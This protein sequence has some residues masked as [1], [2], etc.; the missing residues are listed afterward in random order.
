M[1]ERS[2]LICMALALNGCTTLLNT[3]AELVASKCRLGVPIQKAQCVAVGIHPS[4]VKGGQLEGLPVSALK[5]GD[6]VVALENLPEE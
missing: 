1:Y 6:T 3:P 2:F 4:R 5:Y